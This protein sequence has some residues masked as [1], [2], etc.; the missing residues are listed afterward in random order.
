MACFSFSGIAITGGR[1]L[2]F[3]AAIAAKHRRQASPPLNSQRNVDHG[4]GRP[5]RKPKH[6]PEARSS[7]APKKPRIRMSAIIEL[8][9]ALYRVRTPCASVWTNVHISAS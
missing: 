5:W 9:R 4:K 7:A 6:D 8:T 3:C 2:R 1:W